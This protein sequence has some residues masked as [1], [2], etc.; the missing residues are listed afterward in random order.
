MKFILVFEVLWTGRMALYI[1]GNE[2]KKLAQY[3]RDSG[4]DLGE[5][6]KN[7]LSIY[8]SANDLV[9][10]SRVTDS[11]LIEYIDGR[12]AY[13]LSG[14]LMSYMDDVAMTIDFENFIRQLRGYEYDILCPL[15]VDEYRLQDHLDKT[16]VYLDKDVMYE[17]MCFYKEQDEYAKS[18]AALCRICIVVKASRYDWKIL[19]EKLVALVESETAHVFIQLGLCNKDGVSAIMS[20]DICANIDLTKMLV[21]KYRNDEFYGSE[22][23]YYGKEVAEEYKPKHDEVN[24]NRRRVVQKEN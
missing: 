19:Y 15:A 13:V 4:Y 6:E 24:L 14:Y 3:K 2:N 18:H 16:R 10:T 17:R 11:G 9:R 8:E 5:D 22:V 12:V 23:L 1:L 7:E 21:K 20:R